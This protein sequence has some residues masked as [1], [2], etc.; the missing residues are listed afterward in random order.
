MDVKYLKAEKQ[1]T[2]YYFLVLIDDTKMLE[3][4]S[5]NPVYIREYSWSLYPPEEQTTQEYLDSIKS[6]IQAL[7]D[8][9]LSQMLQQGQQQESIAL[10]GF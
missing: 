6:E 9:E 2:Q 3:D 8:W 4:G 5:P 7:A 1:A 10:E